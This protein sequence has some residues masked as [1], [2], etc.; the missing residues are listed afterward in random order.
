MRK[1]ILH[2]ALGKKYGKEFH[3]DVSTAAEAVRALCTNFPEMMR[4]FREGAWHVIR[5][6]SLDKGL[7][8]DDDLFGSLRLGKADLHIAPLIAGSKRGGLL[9]AI[10]GVVMIATAF[11]FTGGVAMFTTPIMSGISS[12]T[13]GNLAVLGGALALGGISQLLTPEQEAEKNDES[14]VFSGPSNNS[15]QGLAIPL[16]YGEVMTGGVMVSGGIDVEQISSTNKSNSGGGGK[17]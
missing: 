2:G 15:E 14:F 10:L 1:I 4:E 7:D 12:M 13:W 3:F 17:K 8:L 9:K 16:V 5:G 6:S 11:A